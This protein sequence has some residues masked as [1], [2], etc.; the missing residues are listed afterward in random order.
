MPCYR[1]LHS[2]SYLHSQ[3]YEKLKLF[4]QKQMKYTEKFV[5]R[6]KHVSISQTA[7]IFNRFNTPLHCSIEIRD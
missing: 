6:E 5:N 2:H 3:Y 1:S 7:I 4:H